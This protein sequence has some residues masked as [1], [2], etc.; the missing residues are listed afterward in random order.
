MTG[1]L[2][3]SSNKKRGGDADVLVKHSSSCNASNPAC[4]SGCAVYIRT[5]QTKIAAQHQWKRLFFIAKLS[6][7]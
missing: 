5:L 1:G 3:P 2:G 7:G 6:E 4:H